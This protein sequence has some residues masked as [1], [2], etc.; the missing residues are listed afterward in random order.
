MEVLNVYLPV[1]RL[2]ALITGTPLPDRMQGTVLL[3]DMCGFTALTEALARTFGPHRGAE[4]L[5]RRL[6]RVYD[7][8][9]AEVDRYHGSVIGFSG[10]AITCW[11]DDA[12]DG[13]WELGV[14]GNTPTPNSHPPSSAR[15]TACSLAMQQAIKPFATIASP[16]DGAMIDRGHAA[17]AIKVA[18]ASGPI[19]RLLVGDPTVQLIDTL[20]G[21]TLERAAMAE[22]LAREGEVLLDVQTAADLGKALQIVEWRADPA[23]GARFAVARGLLAA[24]EP[25]PWPDISLKE[26]DSVQARAW[27]L[28]AVYARLR[29]GQGEFLTELRPAVAL[30][31]R[32]AGI[33]YDDDDAAGAKLDAYIR[34]GQEVLTHYDGTLLQLTID[35]KGNYIF[36]AFGAPTAH[37]DDARRAAAAARE[38]LRPPPTLGFISQVQIGISQGIM[39][40]G[41]YGGAIRRTYGVLG[42]ETNLAA[43]L[44]EAA[45]PNQMLASARIAAAA[46]S[47]FAWESL[48][49]ITVKGKL[50]PVAVARLVADGATPA[51]HD[52]QQIAMVGR[53]DELRLLADMLSALCDPQIK[54][55]AIVVIEG[56]AGIGKSRLAR[57]LCEYAQARGVATLQGASDAIEQTT[58]YYVWRGVFSQLF[59]LEELGTPAAQRLRVLDILSAITD[60]PDL[61]PLLGPVLPFSIP[62]NELTAQLAGQARAEKTCELLTQLLNVAAQ[63]APTVLLLEDTHWLDSASWAV[64]LAASQHVRPLLMVLVTR[65][66]HDA[67]P[68]EFRQLLDLPSVRHVQLEAL[69]PDQ[70][71]A[72]VHQRLGVAALPEAVSELILQK[73]QGNPFFSEEMLYALRDAG[74]LLVRDGSC[75]LAPEAHDLRSVG[76]PDTIQG[77]IT[78]RIDRLAPSQQLALKVASVIGRLFTLRTLHDIYPVASEQTDLVQDLHNLQ[79]RDLTHMNT[80]A[81]DLS[82]LFKHVITQEVAYSLM[83]FAQRRAL[84][85]TVAEWYERTFEDLSPFYPVLAHHWSRAE[86]TD[87]AVDYLEKAAAQAH[88]IGMPRE[89]VAFGLEAARLL[90]VDLPADPQAIGPLIGAEMA[91]IE[92]LIAGRAPAELID[93]PPL[94]NPKIQSVLSILHLIM[95]AAHNSMQSALFALMTLKNVTLTL[96]HGNG[97]LASDVFAMY[98]VVLHAMTGDSRKAYAFSRLAIDLDARQGRKRTAST[99][100]L[101]TYFINHWVN[102]LDTSLAICMEGSHAGLAGDDIIYG[103]F[104]TAA[105]VIYLST[106]GAPLDQVADVAARHGQ[107]IDSRVAS[108]V[109]HCIHELQI[110]RALAGRTINRLSFTGDE[111]DEERDLASICRTANYNQ[112]AFYYISKLKLHYYYGEHAVAL[113]YADKTLPLLPAFKGQVAEFEYVFFH[114]LAGL[115]HCT[116]CGPAERP[117]LLD[118][119]RTALEKLTGW[120]AVCPA[121]F[122]HKLLLAQAEL[123]RVEG[124]AFDAQDLY[125]WAARSAQTFG[126]IQHAALAHELAGSHL[127]EEG[128]AAAAIKA[129]EQASLTYARWGAWAKVEHVGEQLSAIRLG[130]SED[131][132][133]ERFAR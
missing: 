132:Q 114:A 51:A 50:R 70:T 7:A 17:L 81:P 78:S 117:A 29:A 131:L 130:W 124:R 82:Y 113:E 56:E 14:G 80:P 47:E 49:P 28:P 46:R 77:V 61:A 76:F 133:N 90:G 104:N 108:A 25:V 101:H 72:L 111:Y 122:E 102:P 119:A 88:N 126:Y 20:A 63:E 37:E 85:R 42:D 91:E 99:V 107:I 64:A 129:L 115:A 73:A 71:L 1:D 31:M 116:A 93:L 96:Q 94:A 83:L 120:S 109:F 79:R 15:A 105:Y 10:D 43:R 2:H 44:M 121:N 74:L 33:D 55:S 53:A 13:S 27:V 39:R 52:R 67:P 95:P 98:A 123:A 127:L 112:I 16:G 5:T 19:R 24:V 87:R 22:H 35:A 118:T 30:F 40:T 9:I 36:V 58:P 41:A 38:L 32:F 57:W 125:G 3:V 75:T 106:L 84:H 54:G 18:I 62:D 110:A 48:P 89:S 92:R 11:F 103:C 59:G 97:A 4:E 12:G 69:S 23:S 45:P 66:I 6:N 86:V 60:Q 34:W 65:P 68:P 8:L 21:A 100:F 26:A 128:D